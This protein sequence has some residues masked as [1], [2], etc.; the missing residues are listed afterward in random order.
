MHTT[1]IA[2]LTIYDTIDVITYLCRK[3]GI[4]IHCYTG[5]LLLNA[6]DGLEAK[7][8][9]HSIAP[10][11]DYS[12]QLLLCAQSAINIRYYDK[13]STF[14]WYLYESYSILLGLCIS[15]RSFKVKDLDIVI[16]NPFLGAKNILDATSI[17]EAFVQADLWFPGDNSKKVHAF[18]TEK[19]TERLVNE[20]RKGQK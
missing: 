6:N 3:M 10:M 2:C 16:V 18:V 14:N 11:L 15:I 12:A 1:K 7:V 13:Y 20:G 19:E 17:E 9:G 4:E 5:K 8:L